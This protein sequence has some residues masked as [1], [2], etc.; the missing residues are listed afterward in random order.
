[1][2]NDFPEN[3]MIYF[4]SKITIFCDKIASY[5]VEK[6]LMCNSFLNSYFDHLRQKIVNNLENK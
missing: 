4:W 6:I 2:L 3:I 5:F 1:M